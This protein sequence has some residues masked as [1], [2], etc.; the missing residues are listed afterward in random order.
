[1]KKAK[2]GKFKIEKGVPIPPKANGTG[3][4]AVIRSLKAGDSVEL[5]TSIKSAMTLAYRIYGKGYVVV[6]TTEKGCRIWRIK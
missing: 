3:A 5:Q 6:R 2:V 1:M 4:T